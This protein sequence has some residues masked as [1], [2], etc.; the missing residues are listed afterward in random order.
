MRNAPRKGGGGLLDRKVER[1]GEPKPHI[2]IVCEGEKTEPNYFKAF[3][4]SSAEIIGIGHV[5][6]S[7]VE[8]AIRY[9][10]AADYPYDQVWCV[11]DRDDFDDFAEAITLA[12]RNNMGV[13]YSN[14]AFELWY[15]LHFSFMDSALHRDGYIEI[16]KRQLGTYKKNDRWM[17]DRLIEFQADAIRNAEKL[18][19]SFTGSPNKSDPSTTVHRLVIEL[20][21]YK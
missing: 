16:L 17:Y 6:K 3:R 13:A 11:F 10:D 19:G 21:K 9:R 20:N 5:T 12:E 14:Q 4:V 8:Y 1:R 7:L 18:L 15:L 2:L